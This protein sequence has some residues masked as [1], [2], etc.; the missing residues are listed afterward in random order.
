MGEA[1]AAPVAPAGAGAKSA[2]S[3][4]PLELRGITKS[5]PGLPGV[6]DGVDL[7]LDPGTAVAIVGANG[8]GKTTMLRIACGL[9]RPQS[10][11][12][13][14]AGLD[15]ERDRT[16]FQRRSGFL[17]A[18]NSGLYARLKPEHHLDMWAKLALIPKARRREAI[19]RAATRF[20]L[21]PLFGKRVDRLSMGQRQRLRIALSF[22]HDPEV[23]FLDEPATSLDDEGIG[24]V[25][26]AVQDLK[27]RG[28][29]AVVCQP[30]HWEELPALDAG[31][32][33]TGG[34]L[35]PA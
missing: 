13:T 11:T 9:I 1:A 6:L 21:E 10:G 16:E 8:I 27:A 31:F 26:A 35:E 3:A 19:A 12:V 29:A 25:S 18:G 7:T 30:A 14:L 28:G 32:R 4:P 23:V 33:L 15:S 34:H 17:S 22:L 20:E 2:S 24:L 5:W